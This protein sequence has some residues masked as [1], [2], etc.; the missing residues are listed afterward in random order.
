MQRIE[1][2]EEEQQQQLITVLAIL[3]QCGIK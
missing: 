2:E 1:R 3:M